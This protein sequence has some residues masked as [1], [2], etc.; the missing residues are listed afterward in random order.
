[1]PSRVS[2]GDPTTVVHGEHVFGWFCPVPRGSVEGSVTADGETVSVSGEAYHDHNWGS[3]TMGTMLHHWHWGRA[4]I[5]PYTAV[6][7]TVYPTAAYRGQRTE[8][9]Q[10]VF[11]ASADEVLVNAE[12]FGAAHVKADE[13]ANPDPRNARAYYAPDIT[14]DVEQ[15]D[16]RVSVAFHNATFI[17]GSDLA[18]ETKFL[19][20][21]ERERAQAL[22]VKPWYSRFVASPITLR[23]QRDG[24]EETFTGEG[25]MDF[26]DFHLNP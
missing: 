21:E 14:Y 11:I 4:S 1:V 17:T 13:A 25:V 5:G 20:E 23:V 9:I 10:M 8:G 24:K 7:S 2:P 6:I 26:M 19:S 18:T 12:G 16:K 22:E 3:A 15:D